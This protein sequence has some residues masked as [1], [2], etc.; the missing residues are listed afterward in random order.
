MHWCVI[1][2]LIHFSSFTVDKHGLFALV[3]TTEHTPIICVE[4]TKRR[5]SNKLLCSWQIVTKENLSND[6]P[7]SK[8][9]L[10]TCFLR[11]LVAEAW[12][13]H[14]T[15]PSEILGER[16]V[17]CF[18]Q[19]VRGFRKNKFLTKYEYFRHKSANLHCFAKIPLR[20]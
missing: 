19:W 10:I 11:S 4:K 6:F 3:Y 9:C 16:T 18:R 15:A 2:S 1:T 14:N 5:Q 20:S 17:R 8:I 13:H 12:A 7:P